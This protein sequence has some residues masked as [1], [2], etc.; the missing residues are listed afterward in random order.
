MR[1]KNICTSLPSCIQCHKYK[2]N[3]NNNDDE[4]K[5]EKIVVV[6][7]VVSSFLWH[8]KRE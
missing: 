4:S 7:V 6:L 1:M 8:K 2:T 3:N 5:K